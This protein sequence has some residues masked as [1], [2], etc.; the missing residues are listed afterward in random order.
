M[1]DVII[2]KHCVFVHGCGSDRILGGLTILDKC[3]LGGS[4]HSSGFGSGICASTH[5]ISNFEV[6]WCEGAEVL[7]AWFTRILTA[8]HVGLWRRNPTTNA[9]TRLM[10]LYRGTQIVC[11]YKRM[12][13]DQYH[14]KGELKKQE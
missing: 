1:D 13:C 3:P 6:R 14:A 5:D 4:P 11:G 9:R 7:F 12:M 8:G 2:V 10:H